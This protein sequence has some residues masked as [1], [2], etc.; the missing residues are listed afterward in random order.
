MADTP[1]LSCARFVAQACGSSEQPVASTSGQVQLVAG[2]EA[3]SGLA[4]VVT[5]LARSSARKDA[6]LGSTPELQAQVAEW[7]TWASTE[8]SP[9]MDD[10]LVKL[11]EHL[12]T[13]SFLVGGAASLADLV[14]YALVHPAA[15]TFPAAQTLHFCNLLRWVDLIQATQDGAGFCQPRLVLNRP[16]FVA[17]P[18]PAPPA[19]KAAATAAPGAAD[20]KGAAPAAGKDKAA[21]KPAADG[22]AAVPKKEGKKEAAAAAAPAAAAAAPA[23]AAAAAAPAKEGGKEGKKKD[24]G[25]AAAAPAAKKEGGG[26]A[27]KEEEEASIDMLDCRVGRIVKIDKHP[28]ADSLYL[29]EIDVGED[30]PRQVISGLRNFVPVEKMQDRVVVVVCNLK[31]A[32]MRDVMSYGMVLC[33]SDDAHGTVDPVNVPEGVPVGERLTVEG[34]SNPPLEEVNPKKK[35]LERLFPDMKTDAAGVP[36]YKGKPFLTSKGPLTSTVPNG[37]VK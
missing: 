15:V 33:A 37:W 12:A 1:S 17:P 25:A 6:L 28:N 5:H 13:R 20:A 21:A 34:F 31:P 24:A 30:K 35:L 22:A 32:K 26:A 23:A 19:P 7:L 2:K 8:L 29:E 11:N 4:A 16:R 9:L 14:I 27:K 36:T 10:K 3:I 18:P